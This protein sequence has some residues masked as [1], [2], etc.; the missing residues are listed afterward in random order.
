[1]HVSYSYHHPFGSYALNSASEPGC[2]VAADRNPW[3]ENVAAAGRTTQN[4]YDPYGGKEGIQLGN[5]ISHQEDGQNVL[6]M[7][8]SLRFEDKFF[9]GIDE[10][11]IYTYW[12]STDHRYGGFP[13]PGQSDTVP[14]KRE[15]SLL[16]QDG[17]AARILPTGRGD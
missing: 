11:N 9:C 3:I 1:M 2:A 5:S 4:N 10:D 15:D 8:G 16:V 6:F 12:D 14:Q 13:K 17:E 7:D